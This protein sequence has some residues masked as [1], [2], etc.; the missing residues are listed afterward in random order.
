VILGP[1]I[2]RNLE[3]QKLVREIVNR[4]EKTLLLDGDGLVAMVEHKDMIAARKQPTVLTPHLGELSQLMG[5]GVEAIKENKLEV[6]K[7]AASDLNSIV[8]MKG[9]HTLI[10]YPDGRAYLNPTGN[11]GMA[12][13]GSGDVLNGTIAAV[14]GQGVELEK[15]VRVGVFIHGMSGDLAAEKIGADGITAQEV[16]EFLPSALR[17]YR[18]EAGRFSGNFYDKLARI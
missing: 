3:T 10:G 12:T 15:A 13:A 6:L 11:S 1:G 9:A 17:R 14:H 8:V 4:L 5:V 18:K 2:S 16:L 7:K